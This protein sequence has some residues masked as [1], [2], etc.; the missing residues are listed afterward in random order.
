[1]ITAEMLTGEF[2]VEFRKKHKLSREQVQ[3][4]GD[5]PGKSVARICNIEKN[6]WKDGDRERFMLVIQ[7]V[8]AGDVPPRQRAAREADK[9]KKKPTSNGSGEIHTISPWDDD[10]VDSLV[11]WV[12]T[13]DSASLREYVDLVDFAAE[14]PLDARSEELSRPVEIKMP[15]G[16]EHLY[17]TDDPRHQ[18]NYGSDGVCKGEWCIATSPVPVGQT[19]TTTE[20]V[21]PLPDELPTDVAVLG[22]P[23]LIVPD[24]GVHSFSNSELQGYLRCPRRWWL[25]QYRRLR[26]HQEN[27][28]GTRATGDR[29]HRALAA[30][31]VAEDESRVD[32]RDALER[33][34][35]ED[36]TTLR[37]TAVE[38]GMDEEWIAEL[39]TQFQV[40][41][42]L[43]RAMIEGYVEWLA[44]TGADSGLRVIGS[45]VALAAPFS[46]PVE[47]GSSEVRPARLIGKLDAR[48][49]RASDGVR[50][51][52]DHKTVG[53]LNTPQRTLH[54]NPQMRTYHLL[55]WLTTAEGEARC[56]GA[57]YNMLRRVKRT[58]RATPPFYERVEVRHNAYE[59]DAFKRHVQAVARQIMRVEDLLNAGANLQDVVPANRTRDCS[60]DCD[61]FRVC[62]MFDDGSRVEDALTSHYVQHNP[63]GRYEGLR[64]VS[65]ETRSSV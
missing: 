13:D 25:G 3:E 38:R 4:L 30:W 35:V 52:I 5:F 36:W 65:T 45:E 37:A 42:A 50:L 10:A 60:W 57:L 63:L 47:P 46:V 39:A 23:T 40:A 11:T 56:D 58:A 31:Y 53:D 34:I 29:C 33:V 27:M 14:R 44:E 7:R 26:P 16:W 51:L 62:A 64:V 18:H 17:P 8:E 20:I 15:A 28:T 49:V 19:I 24:D 59:L 9:S 55:E 12:G 61:F 2:V 1:V 22:R 48:V 41:N 21:V 6:S 54:M 32:P 43:E